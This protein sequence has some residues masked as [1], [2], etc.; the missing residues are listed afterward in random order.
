MAVLVNHTMSRTISLIV[1]AVLATL[2]IEDADGAHIGTARQRRSG[3]LETADRRHSQHRVRNPCA[4]SQINEQVLE[5]G[6]IDEVEDIE[7]GADGDVRIKI[8]AVGDKLQALY[9]LVSDFTTLYVSILC[10]FFYRKRC[11]IL[12]YVNESNN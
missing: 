12:R 8:L 2:L 3:L 1:I 9:G 6:Q 7:I 11:L 10:T 5:T 4:G